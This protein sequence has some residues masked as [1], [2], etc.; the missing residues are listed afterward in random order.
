MR[1]SPVKAIV[2]ER[3]STPVVEEEPEVVVELAPVDSGAVAAT[4]TAERGVVGGCSPTGE[5]ATVDNPMVAGTTRAT[6]ATAALT[7][8]RD[9]R[10]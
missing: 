5:G 4:G 8:K 10:T 1:K 6:E 7:E 3:R 2:N 9:L